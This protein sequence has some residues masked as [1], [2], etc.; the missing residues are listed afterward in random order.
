[1]PAFSDSTKKCARSIGRWIAHYVYGMCAKSFNSGITAVDGAIG[2]AVGA[3]VSSEVSK[4]TFLAILA[5]FGTTFGRSCLMYLRDHPIPEKL[6]E[7]T[8]PPFNA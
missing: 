5:I 7:E 2:L 6:P 1:M 8:K 4:P 3:A